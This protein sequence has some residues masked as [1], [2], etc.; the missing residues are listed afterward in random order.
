MSSLSFIYSDV[1]AAWISSDAS[2]SPKGSIADP[3]MR[4]RFLALAQQIQA[5]KIQTMIA[6]WEGSIRGV[7]PGEEYLKLATVQSDMMSSL[8]LVR[9]S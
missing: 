4:E 8:A 6:K 1:M 7:W 9:V 3:A 2:R 5:V